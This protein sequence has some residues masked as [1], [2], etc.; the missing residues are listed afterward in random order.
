MKEDSEADGEL[1][2]LLSSVR[3]CTLCQDLPLGPN[4]IF[5]LNSEAKILIVGQAPGKITH[6]KNIPFDDPSG[7]RL[8]EW[9]GIDREVFYDESKVAILPMAFCYPGTGE[10]GDLPPRKECSEKWRELL[11]ARLVNVELTLVIGRYAMEW[12]LPNNQA[13]TLTETVLSW[14]DYWPLQVPMPHP[15]PRNAR[16]LKN[17]DWFSIELLPVLKER[18]AVLL[19]H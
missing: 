18:I 3:A 2:L 11:L 5:Q 14:Q 17:N 15:S 12:H 1:K 6:A 4:P 9:M 7:K 13:A 8:R 10:G 19:D 16:W